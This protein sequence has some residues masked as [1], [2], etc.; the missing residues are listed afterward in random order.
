M[1]KNLIEKTRLLNV[2]EC[3]EKLN[4][5][6]RTIYNQIGRRSKKRFPIRPK[7]IGRLIKFDP[8]DIEN[9]INSI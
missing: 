5:S 4:I 9:Y 8:R 7:R 3:A 2:R 1:S 6:P